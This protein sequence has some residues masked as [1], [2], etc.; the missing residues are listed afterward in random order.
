MVARDG[1]FA[2]AVLIEGGTYSHT[3]TKPGRYPYVCTLHI[4]AGMF[5]E[6]EVR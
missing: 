1:S 4:G 3:F 6:I 5:G 2:S